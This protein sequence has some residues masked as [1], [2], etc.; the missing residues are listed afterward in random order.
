M[1]ILLNTSI[2]WKVDTSYSDAEVQ[3][4]IC[5]IFLNGY[6]VLDVRTIFTGHKF[7]P[8]KASIVYEKTSPR[9]DLRRK[10]TANASDKCQQQ[11]DS[12]SSTST[13]A[14]TVTADGNFDLSWRGAVLSTRIGAIFRW[15][16]HGGCWEEVYGGEWVGDEL[17]I[18]GRGRRVREREKNRGEDRVV[19]VSESERRRR[20]GSEARRENME[21]RGSCKGVRKGRMGEK[22]EKIVEGEREE[23]DVEK[24]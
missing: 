15:T 4:Q 5:R 8:N 7:S 9:S 6:G 10:P 19:K 18:M 16:V 23:R 14:T 13:L 24:I 22:G 21:R 2:N 11:P 17:V 1:V 3:A 20:E 12:T